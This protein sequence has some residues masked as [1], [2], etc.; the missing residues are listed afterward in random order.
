MMKP[1]KAAT[2]EELQDQFWLGD[3]YGASSTDM[4]GKHAL[5]KESISG[6]DGT[7]IPALNFFETHDFE[8]PDKL[9]RYSL[10]P[11]GRMIA[12]RTSEAPK[13][14]EIEPGRDLIE[15]IQSRYGYSWDDLSTREDRQYWVAKSR[16]QI[17]DLITKEV[18]AERIDYVIEDGFGSTENFRSTPWISTGIGDTRWK[19]NYCPPN[20]SS[21]DYR[22][23]LSVLN[24]VQFGKE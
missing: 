16:L 10:K 22:W 8:N 23:I 7:K 2:R 11:T 18:I 19:T 3:P 15:F 13:V 12:G 24:N 21:T 9:W 14:P 20:N 1:R 4:T 17:V 5:L 6:E